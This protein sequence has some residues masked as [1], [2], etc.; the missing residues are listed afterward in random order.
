MPSENLSL[1]TNLLSFFSRFQT[2]VHF[3]F[4]ISQVNLSDI[5][6]LDAGDADTAAER[7]YKI[8][9]LVKRSAGFNTRCFLD[10]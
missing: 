3:V 2:V 8:S 9:I 7:C 4:C 1:T 6:R 5:L 10:F